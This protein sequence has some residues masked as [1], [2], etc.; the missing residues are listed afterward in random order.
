MHTC[1]ER[2]RERGRKAVGGKRENNGTGVR[3]ERDKR[4]GRRCSERRTEKQRTD[5]AGERW[6]YAREMTRGLWA[7]WPAVKQD[8]GQQGTLC[9]TTEGAEQQRENRMRLQ[10]VLPTAQRERERVRERVQSYLNGAESARGEGN[11]QERGLCFLSLRDRECPYA[12]P[13]FLCI[14]GHVVVSERGFIL[15]VNK[16]DLRSHF[17]QW[18][19]RRAEP[20]TY[21][22]SELL[23]QALLFQHSHNNFH[24]FS[25]VQL[26]VWHHECLL[27][28]STQKCTLCPLLYYSLCWDIKDTEF[29]EE[30]STCKL[31]TL[32]AESIK[33]EKLCC[34]FYIWQ[35]KNRFIN[36]FW[37]NFSQTHELLFLSTMR[38]RSEHAPALSQSSGWLVV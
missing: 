3:R 27:G 37:L 10:A 21:A 24:H 38:K 5:E 15:F 28:G 23:S 17:M 30:S 35:F 34:Y 26:H 2:A 31:E 6:Q 11:T 20:Q 4:R 33:N 16:S 13:S 19:T 7:L 29:L 14:R 36:R 1:E 9:Q 22:G 8:G 32:L 18:L 12:S 25:S